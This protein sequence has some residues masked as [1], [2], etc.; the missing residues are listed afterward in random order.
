[1]SLKYAITYSYIDKQW[2]QRP[3]G[4]RIP[5]Y[6]VAHDSGNPGSTA[7]QNRK[8]FNSRQLTSAAHAFIDDKEIL[9]IIPLTEKAHHVRK[10]VSDANDWA[11][12]VELCYGDKINFEEAYKRY[13]WF[14][15]YLCEIYNWNPQI[16]IKGHYLLDPTRRSD[17]VSA[18]SKNGKT[19]NVFLKD[20]IRELED[21]T[22]P[23][24]QYPVV[25]LRR[26]DKNER[27]SKLQIDLQTISFYEGKVDGIY[28][29]QTKN[30]VYQFQASAKI[31]VDG[32]FGSQT[33]GAIQHA[34]E[35]KHNNTT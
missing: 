29:P 35:I 6:G 26:G 34:L 15:A 32:I 7:A 18:F 11:I 2:D 30:A 3:G 24:Q 8:Y 19:W 4:Y 23:V 20:V 33:A 1:M 22:V 12:G 31:Q 27:V 16:Q 28:G 9:V 14:F 17:P 25:T 5:R 10:S 13:V 21:V